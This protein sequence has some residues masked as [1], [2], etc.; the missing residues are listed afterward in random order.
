MTHNA[1]ILDFVKKSVTYVTPAK[2]AKAAKPKAGLRFSAQAS[3]P[4]SKS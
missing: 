1:V 3:T 4:P 2:M